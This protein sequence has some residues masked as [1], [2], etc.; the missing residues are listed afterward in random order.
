MVYSFLG[1]I[2][3]MYFF[4]SWCL[5]IVSPRHLQKRLRQK[6]E[7]IFMEKIVERSDHGQ[8]KLYTN[9]SLRSCQK[10]ECMEVSCQEILCKYFC[11]RS[12]VKT[13]RIKFSCDVS[14]IL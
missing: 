12:R 9:F 10:N 3:A 6:C 5:D 2:L 4:S 13:L 1:I 7:I 14:A 8:E 11:R